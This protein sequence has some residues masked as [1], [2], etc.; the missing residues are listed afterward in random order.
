MQLACAWTRGVCF[1]ELVWWLVQLPRSCHPV[2]A[3]HP[4][5]P[6]SV[7][8]RLSQPR[9]LT[10][11]LIALYVSAAA[12]ADTAA[13]RAL[14]IACFRAYFGPPA[15]PFAPRLESSFLCL[16]QAVVTGHLTTLPPAMAEKLCVAVTIALLLA[17]LLCTAVFS[18]VFPEYCIDAVGRARVGTRGRALMQPASCPHPRNEASE[19][20]SIPPSVC[21]SLLDQVWRGHHE[22][23]EHL[24]HMA[25]Y[26]LNSKA[27]TACCALAARRHLA[28]EPLFQA[29]SCWFLHPLSLLPRSP[30]VCC[31]AAWSARRGAWA[32]GLCSAARCRR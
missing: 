4:N 24:L 16:G 14:W 3:P 31:G 23:L 22:G 29:H 2:F 28:P 27:R 6:L 26:T 9:M 25:H 32:L 10:G 30:R 1:W 11:V 8:L 5:Y 13:L 7:C 21:A 18:L 19:L 17:A 15:T 20:P 12:G